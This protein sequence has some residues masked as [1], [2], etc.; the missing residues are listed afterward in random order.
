[1]A[2]TG[3]NAII[4]SFYAERCK[5]SQELAPRLEDTVNATRGTVQLARIDVGKPGAML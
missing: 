2:S 3:K 1:M 4:L 5:V